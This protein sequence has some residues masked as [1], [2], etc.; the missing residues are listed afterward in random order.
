VLA[1]FGGE[2]QIRE[3]GAPPLVKSSLG[4]ARGQALRLSI[5]LEYLWWCASPSGTPEP[6]NI[7]L[8]AVQAATGLM[9]AY[10]LPM[11]ARVLGDCTV[12]AEERNGRTLAA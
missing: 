8:S 7:S 12:P 9:N 3:S 5:V 6:V 2:M 10:F 11:G 1:D 4:K